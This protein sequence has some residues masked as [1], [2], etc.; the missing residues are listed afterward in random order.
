MNLLYLE[1]KKIAQ[2]IKLRDY[3]SRYE[4][5]AYRYPSQ[6][7]RYKQENWE[8]VYQ[9][10]LEQNEASSQR[11]LDV[12]DKKQSKFF[13]FFRKG[14]KVNREEDLQVESD[15]LPLTEIDLRQYFLDKLFPLQLKWATSTVTEVSFIDPHY[16]VDQHLKYF[17]Q[18][19]PDIYLVMY[20]PIFHINKAPVDGEIILL[21]PIGI[22]IIHLIDIEQE[23]T[24]FANDDRTW[25]IETNEQTLKQISP[26]I[27]LKRTEQIVKSIL[28]TEAVELPITKTVLARDHHIVFGSEPYRT[29]LIGKGQ[30]QQWFQEKRQLKS[31]LK[32]QQLKAAELLLQYCLSTSVKRPEWDLD[33]NIIHTNEREE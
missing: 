27:S 5:N 13:S 19:F 1:V 10:W 31:I 28:S 33:E 32:N 29:R 2:L 23:A 18:R 3:V 6:F 11:W 21:S 7:I 22:D 26:L 17:L 25:F 15:N 9:L 30:Y 24:I 12:Q 4:W 20:Y 8:Y 14:E 16:E